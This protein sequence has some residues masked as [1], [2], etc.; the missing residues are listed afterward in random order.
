MADIMNFPKTAEEF[1]AA[2]EFK[3]KE[4]IYTN[5]SMLIPS[6][7]VKQLI[8]HYYSAQN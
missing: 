4:Q 7:R 8:E 6:F 3:D 5:G 1:I 2:Y